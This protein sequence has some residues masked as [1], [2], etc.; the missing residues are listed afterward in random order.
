[1]VAIRTDVTTQVAKAT[2]HVTQRAITSS[3]ILIGTLISTGGQFQRAF[4]NPQQ[5][6]LWL[7]SGAAADIDIIR[8][9]PLLVFGG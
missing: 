1:M 4:P 9:E 8:V 2:A 7:T 5:L 6:S 3:C